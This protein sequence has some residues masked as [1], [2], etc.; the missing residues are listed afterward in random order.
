MRRQAEGRR[1]KVWRGAKW[2]TER[3]ISRDGVVEGR[4]DWRSGFELDRR[5][6]RDL[7]ITV[8]SFVTGASSR[9]PCSKKPVSIEAKIEGG[10]DV[11]NKEVVLIVRSTMDDGSTLICF[12][13]EPLRQTAISRLNADTLL[14]MRER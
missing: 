13:I 3:R 6:A 10:S 1:A 11:L 9:V 5:L 12:G 8:S 2:D 4:I 14:W 7:S